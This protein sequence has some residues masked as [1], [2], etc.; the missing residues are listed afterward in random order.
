MYRHLCALVPNDLSIPRNRLRKL[1]NTLKIIYFTTLDTFVMFYT[2]CQPNNDRDKRF[3]IGESSF[4]LTAQPRDNF[5]FHSKV[6]NCH[7]FVPTV[8]CHCPKQS[9]EFHFGQ[10]HT[11]HQV[12]RF[13]CELATQAWK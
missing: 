8:S 1:H 13:A 3:N 12:S 11:C 10:I 6:S 2:Q 4:L 7:I 5:V 9:P